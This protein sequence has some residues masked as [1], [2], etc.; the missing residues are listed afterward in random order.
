[1]GVIFRQGVTNIEREK[2][3]MASDTY[4]G[5]NQKY[6]LK[7]VCVHIHLVLGSV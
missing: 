7:W 2:T 4:K 3:R 5:R 6:R 1:M